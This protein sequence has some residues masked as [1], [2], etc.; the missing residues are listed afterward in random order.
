MRRVPPELAQRFP[1]VRVS[2]RPF[3]EFFTNRPLTAMELRDYQ[4]EIAS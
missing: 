3:G 1:N 2:T 4:I